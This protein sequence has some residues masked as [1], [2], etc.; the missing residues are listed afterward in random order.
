LPITVLAVYGGG[1]SQAAQHS[2]ANHPLLMNL[3]GI[4][5]A[6]PSTPADA[7]GLLK[8][9]IRGNQ[10][11]FFLEA[12]GLGASAGEVPD[13]EFTVPFG[14][15]AIVSE[16][17]HVTLV[18][19]GSMFR[20]TV[21]AAAALAGSGI[22]AEVVDVRTLVPLD[23]ETILRSVAKTGRLVIVDE[24]RERCSAASEIAALVA[25]QGFASLKARIRRVTV[26]NVSMP[27]A[28]NAELDVLPNAEKIAEAA[29]SISAV[30]REVAA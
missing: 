15:A 11:S 2:D 18:T 29:R 4:N 30:G 6:V 5:V 12:A 14:K 25:E 8:S 28:P 7:K 24:A 16:G 10:P 27:Y 1:S 17:V 21:A 13:G 19:V 26:P 3:G 20:A 23:E 9:A 22:S